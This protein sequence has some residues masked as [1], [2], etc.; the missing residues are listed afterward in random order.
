M[1]AGDPAAIFLFSFF[2]ES[3]FCLFDSLAIFGQVSI[4]EFILDFGVALHDP[5]LDLFITAGNRFLDLRDCF[6][7]FGFCHIYIFSS[8]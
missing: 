2:F 3:C 7:N 5:L 6:H 1:A 8:Y 4:Y